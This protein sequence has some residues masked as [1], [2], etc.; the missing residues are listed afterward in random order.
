VTSGGAVAVVIAVV[1]VAAARPAAAWNATPGSPPTSS[2]ETSSPEIDA[3]PEV[4]VAPQASDANTPTRDRP[5]APRLVR[6][7]PP[8]APAPVVVRA[9][10]PAP[11]PPRPETTEAEPGRVIGQIVLGAGAMALTG[12]V[13]VGASAA[14]NSPA[15]AFLFLLAGPGLGGWFVC[16]IGRNSKYYDGRCGAAIGGAYLGALTAVPLAFLFGELCT[17]SPTSGGDEGINLDCLGAAVLGFAIGYTVGT[18]VGATIGWQLDKK[19]RAVPVAQGL[20]ALDAPGDDW[21]ALRRHASLSG[22][23]GARVAVPLLAFS[24]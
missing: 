4:T 10:P 12:A 20:P 11:G 21:A 1:L 18:A 23:R 9:P 17:P 8:A 14:T 2:P 6:V 22:G 16:G 24:F 19:P 7:P 15:P 3:E 5:V 13:A